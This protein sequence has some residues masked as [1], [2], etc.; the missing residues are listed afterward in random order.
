MSKLSIVLPIS[1]LI[2]IV[3]SCRQ[4]TSEEFILIEGGTFINKNSDSINDFYLGKY[5]VTQKE[6]MKIMEHNPSKF[7]GEDLPVEQVSWYNCIE[8]CNKRSLAEGLSPYYNIDKDTI[9]PVN[10]NEFDS[11]K[12][13]VTI[14]P[15]VNGYRL[16]TEAE[17][18][19]AAGGGQKS[20][21]FTYSGSNDIE[22]VAWYWRNS[23]DKTLEGE[24]LWEDIDKNQCRTQPIGQKDPNELG[25]YDMSGNVREWC[26]GWYLDKDIGI[27]YLRSQRGGGWLGGEHACSIAYR[28]KFDPNGKGPDQGFRL[29]R[30]AETQK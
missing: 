8:Y 5:E 29:C 13:I 22:N 24:W 19:Y 7:I 27:G 2:L 15:G 16:P 3:C 21:N 20:R 10:K 28:G 18:E 23:G 30:S 25:L 14:N 26:E 6:W 4:E 1:F 12:W 9:D 11:L 17:W